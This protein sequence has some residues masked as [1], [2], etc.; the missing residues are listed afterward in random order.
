MALVRGLEVPL[1]RELVVL[2]LDLPEDC[3][4]VGPSDADL[5]VGSFR[6]KIR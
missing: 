2:G 1:A 3:V 5:W 6:P 4:L